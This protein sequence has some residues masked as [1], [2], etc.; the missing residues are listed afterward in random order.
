MDKDHIEDH[1]QYPRRRQD[2]QGTLGVP[3]RPDH[4][5]GKVVEH[6]KGNAQKI[7]AHIKGSQRQHILWGRHSLQNG[8]GKG[9]AKNGQKHTA[10]RRQRHRRMD[11]LPNC[12]ILPAADA[13][14]HGHTRTYGQSDEQIDDQIG[15]GTGG[16]HRRHRHTAAVP[17]NHHQ[18]RRVKEKL[19]D[20]GQHNGNGI[21]H[22]GPDQGAVEHIDLFPF[23]FFLP[24]IIS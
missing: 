21:R 11:R 20:A 23:H 18:I 4:G 12:S 16:P 8:L 5:S 14:G 2:H 15:N 7:D 22:N 13:V 1:I 6:I 24:M 19:Q 10:D 17:P 3:R 9:H